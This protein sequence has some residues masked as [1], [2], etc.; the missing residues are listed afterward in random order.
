MIQTPVVPGRVLPLELVEKIVDELAS[1]KKALC[2][3]SYV[4]RSFYFRTRYHLFKS[5]NVY[6]PIAP[7]ELA[8]LADFWDTSPHIPSFIRT[9][10]FSTAFLT[11]PEA[12]RLLRHLRNVKDAYM[13][14]FFI[15]HF[16]YNEPLEALAALDIGCLTIKESHFTS[17]NAFAYVV[18]CFPRLYSLNLPS[19][20]ISAAA[21]N[22]F[23]W[24]NNLKGCA[25]PYL[26]HLSI[27][28]R[29]VATRKSNTMLFA[30]FPFH[31]QPF[32]INDL[33]TFEVKCVNQT[34]LIRLGRF[35]PHTLRTLKNLC[36]VKADNGISGHGPE[37][38]LPWCP[39]IRPLALD[40]CERILIEI[41]LKVGYYADYLRW[42]IAGLSEAPRIRS[43]YIR[44]S[45][46]LQY[47]DKAEDKPWQSVWRAFG[48]VLED[49][50]GLEQVVVLLWV[51]SFPRMFERRKE[52][53]ESECGALVGRGVMRVILPE[54]TP[55]SAF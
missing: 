31:N 13:K 42:W 18:R 39:S 7:H 46:A 34:D 53:V 11:E 47:L 38:P 41:G 29:S 49:K 12:P 6:Y 5:F 51:P 35:L 33:K 54:T 8:G 28:A 16:R 4:S 20:S 21:D 24:V 25:P 40:S 10:Y 15:H 50:Q 37:H 14:D 26:K 30:N 32:R 17:L 23:P 52:G 44:V 55:L 45:M 36:I 48:R 19:A 43:I 22:E 3:C 27:T 1:D 9:L 2:A